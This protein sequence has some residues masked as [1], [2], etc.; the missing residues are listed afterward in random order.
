M[1][2]QRHYIDDELPV[3]SMPPTIDLKSNRNCGKEFSN[4]ILITCILLLNI[5]LYYLNN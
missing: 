3:G 2:V 5:V 4:F 1:I